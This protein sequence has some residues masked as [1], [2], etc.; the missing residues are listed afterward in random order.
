M[1][2]SIQEGVLEPRGSGFKLDYDSISA[3]NVIT[4]SL[5]LFIP[6]LGH[7]NA[8]KRCN[9]EEGL[10]FP[11]ALKELLIL[12]G[13]CQ[14]GFK[15]LSTNVTPRPASLCVFRLSVETSLISVGGDF[16]SEN[17]YPSTCLNTINLK[18]VCFVPV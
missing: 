8:R 10:E 11:L 13:C 2:R 4:H 17:P 18:V 14:T 6:A 16:T 9:K 1:G 12:V 3:G 5:H 7:H 15:Q